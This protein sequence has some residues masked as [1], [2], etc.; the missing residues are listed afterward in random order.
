MDET[1]IRIDEL[2]SRYSLQKAGALALDKKVSELP[3]SW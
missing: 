1:L 2:L 3:E